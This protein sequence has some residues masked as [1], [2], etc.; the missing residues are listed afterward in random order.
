M[1]LNLNEIGEFQFENLIRNRIPFVL[2]NLT[3]E[4]PQLFSQSFYQKHVESIEIRCQESEVIEKLKAKN[5]PPHEAILVICE[6]GD[7]SK[8][9]VTQLEAQG[10][11]N[12]FFMAG[13]MK[14]LA[15]NATR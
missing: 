14:S 3:P 12:V 13:G 2:I 5:H 1:S 6:D 10:Y 9:V 11:L 8:L 7:H 15:A 4:L